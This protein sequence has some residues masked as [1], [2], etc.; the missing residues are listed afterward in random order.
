MLKPGTKIPELEFPLLAGGSWA[1]QPEANAR[2]RL[3]SF[4]RGA[5][6]GFCTRFMQQLNDLHTEFAELG[7]DLAG[8]SV[9]S[10][11]VAQ[12]WAKKNQIDKVSV[13]YGLLRKDVE[14][15]GIFASHFSRD[16]QELYFAEPALWL[17]KPDGELY[18]TIQS[19]VSCGRPDLESLVAG[20]KLLAVQGF[21]TRG[22]A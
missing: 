14:A 1:L 16:G 12:A 4:Y 8:V 20:L 11:A 5:F 13:G 6:C 22:N 7:I 19:S 21:P 9:D 15:C 10:R 18:L 3:I 2:L 17:V